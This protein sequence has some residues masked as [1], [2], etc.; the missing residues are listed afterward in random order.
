MK[1]RL[2]FNQFFHREAFAGVV[3]MDK[4]RKELKKSHIAGVL[5]FW[6]AIIK[7]LQNLVEVDEKAVEYLAR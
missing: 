4:L 6:D 2:L 1:L 5:H 7:H 3:T